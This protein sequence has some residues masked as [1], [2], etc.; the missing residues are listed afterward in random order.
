ME[1]GE[2]PDSSPTPAEYDP[3]LEWP[4]EPDDTDRQ[5]SDPGPSSR[6]SLRLLVLRTPVLP[7]KQTLGL[8]DGYTELQIGRDLAPSQDI[9]RIRLKEMEVSKLHA[10]A[11]WDNAAGAWN[12]VDMGSK[13]GTFLQPRSSTTA[14]RLSPPRV[15]SV[16]RQLHHL[17]TLA[18]GS[19][20]FLVH[21]HADVPCS[22]C[23]STFENEI[24]LFVS[25][26]RK[27]PKV[28][29]TDAGYLPA[30]TR[31]PKKALTMLKQR[32]LT[33][34]V[35]GPIRSE[36]TSYTDRS[37]RR[38]SLYPPSRLDAP[39]V[40]PALRITEPSASTSQLLPPIP[41]SSSDDHVSAAWPLPTT[42]VGHRLLLAQGWTPGSSL[43]QA[44][45]EGRAGLTAPLEVTSTTRRAGLGMT[46]V[47]T[48]MTTT[49]S[50]DWR[51]D[52]RQRRWQDL[53]R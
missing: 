18:I 8:A 12:I 6:P 31:D 4:G 49:T 47:P 21:V 38:R 5:T 42:N 13:H 30:T 7:A 15:A 48:P 26:K 14:V 52:G 17:D 37:A 24:P 35:P 43:G 39:G 51:A 11:Y 19:T 23:C 27:A 1:A 46:K 44:W 3:S 53:D 32:L 2:I 50:G 41:P 33:P 45:E 16:P 9:P 28:S 25:Q 36:G 22:E 20:T 29:T 10:T 34:S 40:A